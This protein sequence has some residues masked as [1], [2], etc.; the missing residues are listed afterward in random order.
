VSF[1]EVAGL[2]K[3]YTAPTGALSVIRNLDLSI[4]RGEMVA[5][6]GASGV[7]KST[8][9]HVLGGLDVFEAGHVRIGDA[10]IERM[11]DDAR[12]GF[13]NAHVGFVFQFHHLLP[14]F[15]ALENV[16]MPLFL[17]GVPAAERRARA[18]Q[19]L[20]RVGLSGRLS[21]RPG[22]LSG[23]EQQRVAVA[24][25]LVTQPAVLLADEPTGNLDEGTA[26]DLHRLLH[27]IHAE[28]GLTSVI[29]THN[30]TLAATCDR[31]FRLEGGHLVPVLPPA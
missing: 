3:S 27:Q 23:G 30:P 18:E 13:R 31:V 17:S 2:V 28:N 7:G 20:A 4:E 19:L 9:L 26:A 10:H 11:N 16:E 8:L 22:A 25:A 24:R 6:V 1:I 12:V 14:E 5:I 29:V 15:S 21:H